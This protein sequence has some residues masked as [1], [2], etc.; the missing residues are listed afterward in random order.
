MR[1]L[2]WNAPV[3]VAKMSAAF[4]ALDLRPGESVIDVGCGCGEVLIRLHE[5]FGI[6]GIG[7]DVSSDHID[8]AKRRAEG[9]VQNSMVRFVQADALIWRTTH[10]G[11]TCRS[12]GYPSSRDFASSAVEL[13]GA[14]I[15]A[16]VG[17]RVRYGVPDDAA[18]G[19][20]PLRPAG[21]GPPAGSRR[22][23]SVVS[24]SPAGWVNDGCEV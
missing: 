3:S 18:T 17:Y 7:V 6:E 12:F 1:E 16:R 21:S 4:D 19:S 24:E 15:E 10:L 13:S 14:V 22:N 11:A 2:L 8:E 5:C 20:S 9:R 23:L